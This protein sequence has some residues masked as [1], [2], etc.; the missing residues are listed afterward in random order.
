MADI[1]DDGP[2]LEDFEKKASIQIATS[3]KNAE[4]GEFV[5]FEHGG[6]GKETPS[7][8]MSKAELVA[9]AERRGITVVPDG[10]TKAQI[11]G[12]IEST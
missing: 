5:E 7:L 1:K 4:A 11:L 3:V 6:V 2:F 8:K 10:M 9:E 12:A